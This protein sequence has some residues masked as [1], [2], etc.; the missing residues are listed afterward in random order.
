MTLSHAIDNGGMGPGLVF[1]L[2]AEL[3]PSY[4][5]FNHLRL[6]ISSFVDHGQHED[7]LILDFVECSVPLYDRINSQI[8]HHHIWGFYDDFAT[9]WSY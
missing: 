7:I 9:F 2:L 6:Q 1:C 5:P 4:L 8:I 3:V